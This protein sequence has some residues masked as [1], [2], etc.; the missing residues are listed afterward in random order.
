MMMTRPRKRPKME[1][2]C[3][4]VCVFFYGATRNSGLYLPPGYYE[5]SQVKANLVRFLEIAKQQQKDS[6]RK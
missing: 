6:M 4:I 3:C 5:M 1:V 2:L